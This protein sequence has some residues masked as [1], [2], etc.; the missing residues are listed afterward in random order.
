MIYLILVCYS[1]PQS[2]GVFS[3]FLDIRRFDVSEIVIFQ[4]SVSSSLGEPGMFIKLVTPGG[5]AQNAGLS[6]NDRLVEVNGENIEGLSHAQVVNVIKKAGN[7]LMLLVVDEK[8]DEY[9]K[10]KSKKIGPWLASVKH[11]PHKPRI[12]YVRKGPKGF[13]FTLANE[14]KAGRAIVTFGFPG[15]VKSVLVDS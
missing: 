12:T 13:G 14:N 8:T 2:A 3:P 1:L 11:L 5:V 6:V 7:S 4:S 10:K 15:I 9:Y